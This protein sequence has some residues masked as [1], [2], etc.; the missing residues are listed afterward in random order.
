MQEEYYP[1]IKHWLGENVDEILSNAL[2][3]LGCTS[4][5][6][7]FGI[8]NSDDVLP[9]ILNWRYLTTLELA[10]IMTFSGRGIA[11]TPNPMRD[12]PGMHIRAF[13]LTEKGGNF[14]A[15]LGGFPQFHHSTIHPQ[16]FTK[17]GENRIQLCYA[18]ALNRSIKTRINTRISKVSEK[19][20]HSEEILKEEEKIKYSDIHAG[21]CHVLRNYRHVLFTEIPKYLAAAIPNKALY[22]TRTADWFNRFVPLLLDSSKYKNWLVSLTE[23]EI[24]TL[25]DDVPELFSYFSPKYF[26]SRVHRNFPSHPR[27]LDLD[28]LDSIAI[29]VEGKLGFQIF[30]RIYT[31]PM[32]FYSCYVQFLYEVVADSEYRKT[33]GYLFEEF[34]REKLT[35]KGL[36]VKKVILY[37]RKEMTNPIYSTMLQNLSRYYHGPVHQ[38]FTPELDHTA[39]NGNYIEFDL[40]ARQRNR[41][42]FIEC[43]SRHITNWRELK[44][45]EWEK[46]DLAIIAKNA[47]NVDNFIKYR[48]AWQKDPEMKRFFAQMDEIIRVVVKSEGFISRPTEEMIFSLELDSVLERSEQ[49]NSLRDYDGIG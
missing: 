7:Y 34:L 9:Q 19:L 3:I 39:G 33:S 35:R 15:Y 36:E 2:M 4:S 48:K 6:L 22:I 40:I 25:F 41:Y 8:Q 42:F 46:E 12:G 37:S 30:S 27:L 32:Q 28:Q 44:L 14:R 47:K 43:K 21:I 23:K 13:F 26:C 38:I 31:T 11:P 1:Q 18:D 45:D 49:I 29:D 17:D 24:K 16:I 10:T 20:K 5:A